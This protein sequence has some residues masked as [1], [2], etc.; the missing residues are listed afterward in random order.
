MY[1]LLGYSVALLL[2]A[3]AILLPDQFLPWISWRKESLA[4]AA[5]ICAALTACVED[6]SST[7]RKSVPITIATLAAIAAV[8]W[9]QL[10]VGKIDYLGSAVVMSLYIGLAICAYAVGA[11]MS[12]DSRRR[13][14]TLTCVTAAIVGVAT[15][16]VLI[17]MCQVLELDQNSQWIA[18]QTQQRRPGGNL[19]QP[20]HLGTLVVMALAS[21]GYLYNEKKLGGATALTLFVFIGIGMALTESRTALLNLLVLCVLWSA[22]RHRSIL[23]HGSIAIVSICTTLLAAAFLVWPSAYSTLMVIA[24]DGP[25]QVVNTSAGLRPTVWL[26][27]VEATKQ[28]PWFGWGLNEVPKALHASL[29]ANPQEKSEAYS[30]SHNVV[31]DLVIGCG[32]PLALVLVLLSAAWTIH[33]LKDEKNGC[34]WTCWAVPLPIVI[35]SMLEFPFAYAYFL[36]PLAF[37]LGMLNGPVGRLSTFRIGSMYIKM[38][39]ILFAATALWSA[40]EYVQ[41]EED[42]RVLRFEDLKIGSPPPNYIRPK[43]HLLTQLDALIEG[44]RVEPKRNM[45]TN[46]IE[47]MR[48]LSERFA[49]PAI[50]NRYA[51][52]LALNGEVEKAEAELRLMKAMY[53][54]ANYAQVLRHWE[55]LGSSKYPELIMVNVP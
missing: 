38:L 39:L 52:A 26:Q 34:D 10:A 32:Y 18:Q 45:S 50:Q 36:A 12:A 46:S 3:S 25:S 24:P 11:K 1:K 28:Q 4:F 53:A 23:S 5:V 7:A 37:M 31:L 54:P 55:Y 15:I 29:L 17:A 30:Y 20:N 27:L 22:A 19:S 48:R 44:G 40:I 51:L 41:V 47:Q 9:V 35:H 21:I 8:A 33:R 42:F 16:S 2:W 14:S 6:R 49:W 43:V 13:G